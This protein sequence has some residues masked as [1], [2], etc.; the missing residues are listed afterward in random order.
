MKTIIM[1]V[2]MMNMKRTMLKIKIGS[3]E[4]QIENKK[5]IFFNN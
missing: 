1:K 5:K 3:L 2:I 4:N